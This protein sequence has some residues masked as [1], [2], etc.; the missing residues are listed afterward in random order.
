MINVTT[1]MLQLFHYKN[2][3]FER[4]KTITEKPWQN[5]LKRDSNT[6]DFLWNLRNF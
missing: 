5:M 3:M 1:F 2:I 4:K 6:D